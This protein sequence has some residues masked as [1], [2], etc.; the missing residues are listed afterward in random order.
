MSPGEQLLDDLSIRLAELGPATECFDT[1]P[2]DMRVSLQAWQSSRSFQL[3]GP[4]FVRDVRPVQFGPARNVFCGILRQHGIPAFCTTDELE[5]VPAALVPARL[6]NRYCNEP[7]NAT[8][9]KT[10]DAFVFES[11]SRD[12][13]SWSWPAEI[14]GELL[15]PALQAARL[16]AGDTAIGIGLP[17]GC[18]AADVDKCLSANCDFLC[19]DS[20]YRRLEISD[21]V[22]LVRVRAA[23]QASAR[24][25][26]PILANLPVGDA[27]QMTKLLALGAT[28]LCLDHLLLPLLPTSATAET[29]TTGGGMLREITTLAAKKPPTL[30]RIDQA[31]S[32]VIGGVG[33]RANLAGMSTLSQLDANSLTAYSERASGLT[34]VSLFGSIIEQFSPS[35]RFGEMRR[36]S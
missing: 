13:T 1:P 2:V 3:A 27:E 25:N 10:A 34:G 8:E 18:S 20:C 19:L 11:R 5:A 35:P 16:V 14:T 36:D 17:L 24:P 26:L 29:S 21:I 28:A 6:A 9:L 31:L 12:A 22:G 23:V 33:R 30:P 32:D 7:Y 4:F 15:R